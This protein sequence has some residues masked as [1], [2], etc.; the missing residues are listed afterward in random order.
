MFRGRTL[1][2]QFRTDQEAAKVHSLLR[3]LKRHSY[4]RLFSI[5]E[6]EAVADVSPEAADTVIA[7]IENLHLKGIVWYFQ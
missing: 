3:D 6:D 1:Q 2:I 7:S 4:V 5:F